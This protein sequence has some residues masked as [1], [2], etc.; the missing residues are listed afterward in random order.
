MAI[1]VALQT[2]VRSVI[3]DGREQHPASHAEVQRAVEQLMAMLRA[4]GTERGLLLQILA[5]AGLAR[6]L[7]SSLARE[8]RQQY[9]RTHAVRQAEAVAREVTALQ[10]DTRPLGR[11]LPDQYLST[12]LWTLAR[13]IERAGIALRWERMQG[14][15]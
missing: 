15:R 14:A 2:L 3:P 5:E 13:D 12:R 8:H 7:L 6:D 4:A 10:Y 1:A 11:Y 9:G